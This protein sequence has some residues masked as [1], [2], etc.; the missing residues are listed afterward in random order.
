MI[1]L[2]HLFRLLPDYLWI[3]R[4]G[5]FDQELYRKAYSDVVNSGSDPILHYLLYGWKEGRDPGLLFC[6]RDYLHDYPDVQD[7]N[8]NP[9]V[10]YLRYGKKEGRKIKQSWIREDG[11]I[12]VTKPSDSEL[13]DIEWI[14]IKYHEWF[15]TPLNLK[16]P[17]TYNEKINVYKLFYRDKS[18]WKYADK[19]VV[20]EYIEQR[21]GSKYLIP[22]VGV[23]ESAD[24]IRFDK[25]PDQFVIKA[26]HGSGWNIIC[27]DKNTLDWEKCKK[28]LAGWLD[29]N[30]Y[31]RFREWAYK[32][33]QPRLI[34]EQ[35]LSDSTGNTPND[36]KIFCF[37]GKPKLIQVDYN[38]LAD[39]K[40]NYY[41]T[42][43]RQKP[44]IKEYPPNDVKEE[45]P[46]NLDEMLDLAGKLSSDFPHV[47]VDFF[48]VPEIY[49]GEMT[50][51]SGGGSVPYK[52]K[53]WDIRIGH[54]FSVSSFINR[55]F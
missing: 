38:R 54:Y 5:Y 46:A 19:Y 17:K 16:N 4:S 27:Q 30:F 48:T 39:H 31:D 47:R 18:L 40:R 33:I 49:F 43:W 12:P 42:A 2:R 14:R 52:P 26:T 1:N 11:S 51:Y 21:I 53:E 10:H 3:S 36:Y 8:M 29:L 44:I 25:L 7:G 32:D 34:I 24:D 6:T 45:K 37:D 20:R 28:Q 23:Y 35:Y 22:L 15:N 41:D 55:P 13:S 50:F 9:L